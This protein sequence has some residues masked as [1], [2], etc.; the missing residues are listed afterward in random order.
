[1]A[2]HASSAEHIKLV[3]LTVVHAE[4]VLCK[5]QNSSLS[6]AAVQ[7][8]LRHLRCRP[9]HPESCQC[10]HVAHDCSRHLGAP[11]KQ[12]KRPSCAARTR[13]RFTRALP[14]I[15]SRVVMICSGLMTSMATYCEHSHLRQACHH[16]HSAS[17][18]HQVNREP[19][20]GLHCRSCAMQCTLRLCMWRRSSK[21]PHAQAFYAAAAG[22]Y[23]SDRN[24]NAD[25]LTLL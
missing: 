22:G 8:W 11:A 3:L 24:S 10:A 14:P 16:I 21:S 18:D 7:A 4:R 20:L 17:C 6:K 15:W 25:V 1:M 5:V 13:S 9:S 12:D 19:Q 23:I 2:E